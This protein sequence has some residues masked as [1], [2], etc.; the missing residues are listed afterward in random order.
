M[1]NPEIQILDCQLQH[2]SFT[3]FFLVANANGVQCWLFKFGSHHT[4]NQS[5]KNITQLL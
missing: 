3:F 4:F 5:N 1:K 2:C